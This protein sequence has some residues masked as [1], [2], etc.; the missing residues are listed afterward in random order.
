MA[1]PL[2]SVISAL[3]DAYPRLDV[4]SIADILLLGATAENLG[5]H[6]RPQP[7]ALA[8]APD[9]PPQSGPAAPGAPVH[10]QFPTGSTLLSGTTT[11]VATARPLANSLAVGRAL[12]PFM[13]PWP[14]GRRAALDIDRTVDDYA[15][16]GILV[17][18]MAPE[19]ERWF[20]VRVV[21]DTS[22]SMAVWEEEITALAT[23]MGGMGAFRDV[24]IWKLDPETASL[25]DDRDRPV[26]GRL[27]MPG[28]RYLVLVV[29]DFAA[30][31][32]RAA[33]SWARVHA[34]A[35]AAPTA[36]VDPLPQ[37]LWRH[38]GLT[39]PIVRAQASIPGVGSTG[40]N[41][42]LPLRL[43]ILGHPA[44]HWL[45]IPVTDFTTRGLSGWARAVMRPEP[46]GCDAVLVAPDD[47]EPRPARTSMP[48]A[49]DL[50][51]SFLHTAS[52]A[53]VRLAVL[54]SPFDRLS[55]PLLHL[56]RHSDV[57]DADLADVAE[58]LISGLL[59]AEHLDGGHPILTFRPGAA[60]QLREHLSQ[61]DAWH[62]F[63]A[64]TRYITKN[65]TTDAA[66]ISAVIADPDAAEFAVE[67]H[68]FATATANIL[69]TL[70]I[71]SDVPTSNQPGSVDDPQPSAEADYSLTRLAASASQQLSVEKTKKVGFL[72]LDASD[73]LVLA[74]AVTGGDLV[75]RD[76]GL[77]DAAAHR[78]R[79]TVLTVEAY[80]TLWLKAA[81]L[82][83]S[84]V[85]TRPLVEGNWRLGWVAAVTLCD[86]NG[87]WVGPD[88]DEALELVRDVSRKNIGVPETAAR[89][90]SW[91]TSKED[92][93]S[94]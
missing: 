14:H 60:D 81:A 22:I 5:D 88:E 71:R 78:P 16:S 45:P 52:A 47:Q 69:H 35:T 33:P 84:I 72:Y 59:V 1:K 13:R 65:S 82:L 58:F 62:T 7:A 46:D 79:A 24:R 76:L 28:G 31:G 54:C 92:E 53:A 37:R 25:K 6:R 68:P 55:L 51:T 3:T 57:P 38:S 32:W 87:W 77:I 70:G 61:R 23:L 48:S 74:A 66:G 4:W 64:I 2:Q 44:G 56:V 86:M 41:Y 94:D 83:D 93:P 9:R 49:A 10:E 8:D 91:A 21:A 12:Q 27:G 85:S 36:L 40:L 30:P 80:E 20:D 18:V 63:D 43:R 39:H 89:L 34:L 75:V 42:R 11:T 67:P 15:R 90:E 73:L 26:S 19:P 17:P 50:V 29:S